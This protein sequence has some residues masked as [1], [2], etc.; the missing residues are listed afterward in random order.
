MNEESHHHASGTP[1]GAASHGDHDAHERH[2]ADEEM[3][4]GKG[5]SITGPHGGAHSAHGTGA[6]HGGMAKESHH[7]HMIADMRRRFWVCLALTVP[8]LI[9]SPMIQEWLGIEEAFA[10]RGDT[11]VLFAL[12]VAVYLYGGWPFLKGM[13]DDLSARKPGMMTLVALAIT[14]AF[15]YSSVVV[16][17][18][19]GNLLF[20]E[21][22]TLID[23]MLLGHWL[24][25]RSV[26]GA[27]RA[28]EKLVELLPSRA[29]LLRE[30]GKVEDVAVESLVSGDRVLVKPGEKIPVDGKVV[31]GETS[32]DLSL[33]TGESRP[34]E[35]GPGDELIGGA[36]NGDGAVE[37]IVE[38]T[39]ADTYLSQV[40][41]M[42]RA[43]QESRSRTQNLADR[44][45]FWLTLTAIFAGSMTLAVWLFIGRAFDFSLERSVTVMVITCPHALGL[46]IPLVVAVSTALSARNGLLVRDR[47][48][49]ERSRLLDAVVF[50]KTGTLTMGSFGVTDVIPLA[51]GMN[52]DDVLRLAAA[53]ES[54]S[55]HT[56]A[57]GV[58]AEAEKRGLA[59][60]EP[61]G[62]KALPG[63]GATAHL[64]GR[65]VFVVSPGFLREKGIEVDDSRLRAVGEQGKTLVYLLLDMEPAGAVALADMV[66]EESREAVERLESR[67]VQCMMLTG[68][69][70][71]V[72]EWVAGELGLSEYFAEVLPDEKSRKIQELQGRGLVV[73]MVGDGVNDAP[74]LAQADV[75]IAIGAGTDVAMEAADIVLVRNDPRDV[76]AVL[77]LGRATYRK[78]AQNL[79]WATGYNVIA[80]P[81]AAGVLYPLGVLLSP[82]V[83][84]VLMSLS[85]IIVAFNARLLKAPPRSA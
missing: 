21:L 49:F 43:A 32:V 26:M 12:S 38:K 48:A 6:G 17:G 76:D 67:G 35:R 72:A 52:E 27:S 33:V 66:R 11:Y 61:E 29:H 70:R 68:D 22:A 14:V 47:T 3:A 71:P 44:A 23:I 8:I 9:L 78:M 51:D 82:A 36:V 16:F 15:V 55:E 31:K 73:A 77:G 25:M 18:L 60:T 5:A 83:G 10:F 34:E 2:G 24:E 30:E 57:R 56:I 39:G 42:V 46:A 53:V 28:L 13:R 37:M 80:I 45:A 79:G 7:A 81:L 19:Q 74:A 50:D 75:G 41:E 62:F 40:I 4:P 20:W 85:T 58:V 84:A 69:S 63:K 64:E 65:E 59:F 54:R 1:S